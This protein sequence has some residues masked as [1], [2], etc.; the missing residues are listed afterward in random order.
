MALGE[1]APMAETQRDLAQRN[2]QDAA[3][4]SPK[5]KTLHEGRPEVE[6]VVHIIDPPPAPRTFTSRRKSR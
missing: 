2:P 3:Q 4:K 5:T 6:R 1:P